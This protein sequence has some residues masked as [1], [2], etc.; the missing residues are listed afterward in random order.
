MRNICCLRSRFVAGLTFCVLS[1]YAAGVTQAHKRRKITRGIRI[2]A[3]RRPFSAPYAA[4][5]PGQTTGNDTRDPNLS[6][7]QNEA[8][9]TTAASQSS[10]VGRRKSRYGKP[11]WW[12][13]HPLEQQVQADKHKA[14]DNME[15]GSPAWIRIARAAS[16]G[17]TAERLCP[18]RRRS[19]LHD[20]STVERLFECSDRTTCP[21]RDRAATGQQ[22]TVTLVPG[23]RNLKE[24]G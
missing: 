13:W 1:I 10:T 21:H 17:I 3:I 2:K 12:N 6:P 9:S 23:G 19:S 14:R 4:P 18:R 7:Q 24:P 20:A 16:S 11:T 15:S 5:S 22:M 8:T